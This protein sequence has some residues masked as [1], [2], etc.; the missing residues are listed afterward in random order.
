[1]STFFDDLEL[2]L[3][4]L[5]EA[6]LVDERRVAVR[7]RRPR[8]R[9]ALIAVLLLAVL[10]AAAVAATGIWRPILGLPQFGPGPSISS[11]APPA[12]QLR[13]LG[14]LRRTQ[15]T[16]DRGSLTTQELRYLGLDEEGV[17][18][19]YIRLLRPRPLPGLGPA[20]LVPVTQT[21]LPAG[22]P[23]AVVRRYAI[24]NA[25]CLIVGDTNG[26]GAG[27]TCF[28]TA[29]LVT[30]AAN[31]SLGPVVYGLVPDDVS[32]VTVRFAS[33]QQVTETAQENFVA[34]T[35]PV[36]AGAPAQFRLDRGP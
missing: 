3:R 27:K 12:Q 32:R 23:P 22:S 9:W 34:V 6:P 31:A 2:Q 7:Q 16:A 30:G 24:T 28:S 25:L 29:Q 33:G 35:T 15:T 10:A 1:M 13:L 21:R 4:D 36:G 20:V 5:A 17:R 11:V 19:N 18:T 8:A 14:V 26:A